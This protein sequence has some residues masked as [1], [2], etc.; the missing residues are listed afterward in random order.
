MVK[1]SNSDHALSSKDALERS[2]QRRL[3]RLK[4]NILAA[5]QET[6]QMRALSA[7]EEA[8]E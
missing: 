7:T 5:R 3:R 2:Q 1:R 4:I 6:T 8:T